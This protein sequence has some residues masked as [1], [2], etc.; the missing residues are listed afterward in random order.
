MTERRRLK[1][2][3]LLVAALVMAGYFTTIQVI[4]AGEDFVYWRAHRDAPIEGWMTISFVAHS[5]HVKQDVLHTALGLPTR[6]RDYRPLDLI[7]AGRGE[8]F[9]AVRERLKAA[10]I[11]A[12]AKPGKKR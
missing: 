9:E 6:P 11:A 5:Y 12:R 7:A 10:I 2:S 4:R 1:I 3:W 8:R